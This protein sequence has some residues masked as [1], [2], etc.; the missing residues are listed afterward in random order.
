VLRE[1]TALNWCIDCS[2]QSE[3]KLNIAT[4]FRAGCS[5]LHWCYAGLCN[6]WCDLASRAGANTSPRSK[7][8]A[9]DRARSGPSSCSLRR[10]NL[11]RGA[12][13][14]C[15][16][17]DGFHPLT[18]STMCSQS[19]VIL[20]QKVPCGYNRSIMRSDSRQSQP[21]LS[22]ISMNV[23]SRISDCLMPRGGSNNGGW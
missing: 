14:D 15:S 20:G 7:P 11:N 13:L 17:V 1:K 16:D 19:M 4:N 23:G 10:R 2:Y 5:Y 3:I 21:V 6:D 12:R 18:Q 8:S 22:T 9:K